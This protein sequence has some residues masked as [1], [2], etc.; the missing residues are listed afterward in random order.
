MTKV[1]YFFLISELLWVA[2]I[3]IQTKKISNIW[4]GLHVL[5]AFILYFL[6]ITTYSFRWEVLIFPI[7]ILVLGFLLYLVNVMGAGDSKYLAS[8]FLIIPLDAQS[9][10]LKKLIISTMMTGGLLLIFQILKKWPVLRAYL[11]SRYWKGLKETVRSRFSFAPVIGVA[12]ILFGWELWG[13]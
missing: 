3:D 2:W 4:S 10:F 8:L 9:I 5:L 6:P 12:W 13:Q 7:G 11:W 1:L